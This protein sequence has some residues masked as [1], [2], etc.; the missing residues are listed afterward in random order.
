MNVRAARCA[1][2]RSG[3]MITGIVSQPRRSAGRHA[4]MTDHQWRPPT[5]PHCYDSEAT[6]VSHLRTD[7]QRLVAH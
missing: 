7:E 4:A 6:V 5:S 1:E 3:R 2:A